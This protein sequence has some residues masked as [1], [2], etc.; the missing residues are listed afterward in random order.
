MKLGYYMMINEE[1]FEKASCNKRF[2]ILSEFVFG[3]P[4]I[5]GFFLNDENYSK[6]NSYERLQVGYAEKAF[7]SRYINVNG[8]GRVLDPWGSIGFSAD[9]IIKRVQGLDYSCVVESEFEKNALS[10]M[11]VPENMILKGSPGKID[12]KT[13]EEF[14][15]II[16]AP[17]CG[18]WELY[19]HKDN[20]HIYSYDKTDETARFVIDSLRCLS[21]SGTAFFFLPQGA[22]GSITMHEGFIG[23]IEEKNIMLDG[24]FRLYERGYKP[25]NFREFEMA[26]VKKKSRVGYYTGFMHEG[27]YYGKKLCDNYLQLK[28]SN[29]TDKGFYYDNLVPP[30]SYKSVA[31]THS[32]DLLGKKSGHT[33]TRLKDIA[34]YMN[35]EINGNTNEVAGGPYLY[36]PGNLSDPAE[37]AVQ[38]APVYLQGHY[39]RVMP[40]KA[41][42]DFLCR[43]LN[44]ETG[45]L[46]REENPIS[47]GNIRL[48]MPLP[49]EQREIVRTDSNIAAMA[50]RIELLKNTLWKNPGLA[51]K[52]AEETGKLIGL[53]ITDKLIK[54]LPYPLAAILAR[55]KGAIDNSKKIECLMHFFE[56]STILVTVI[57]LT[58]TASDREFYSANSKKWLINS[59]NRPDWY[60]KPTLGNWTFVLERILKFFRY[61]RYSRDDN[62]S[63]PDLFFGGRNTKFYRACIN[64]DIYN[65][66]SRVRVY[67][68]EWKGHGGAAGEEGEAERAAVLL[69]CLKEIARPLL[70]F[71]DGLSIIKPGR[72][73]FE[74]GKYTYQVNS[75]KG[76]LVVFPSGEMVT[77]VPLDKNRIYL[78]YEFSEKPLELVP[79]IKIMPS[80]SGEVDVCYFYSSREEPGKVRWISYHFE[81]QAEKHTDSREI[82]AYLE[83]LKRN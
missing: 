78:Q 64:F 19:Q 41:D 21:P 6:L 68:N 42:I 20:S 71:F 27:I 26:V 49:P 38:G 5:A 16:C 17:P 51:P 59:G 40:E 76:A 79:F 66:L 75:L 34:E 32:L 67:R 63:A 24:I 31:V 70:N 55:Y 62:M 54:D 18:T 57:L 52:V 30:E 12:E 44:N 2:D 65:V 72:S 61:F 43:Y 81:K 60:N 13:A 9:Y 4:E 37:I 73:E 1:L 22:F 77:S 3:R 45:K 8:A 82:D 28:N 69:Q 29:N 11:G 7:I 35:E 23:I 15:Y 48:F 36:I 46:A 53:D 25:G 10:V 39:F 80:G 33:E 74:D 58:I 56:A 50:R 47:P 14:D 83:L